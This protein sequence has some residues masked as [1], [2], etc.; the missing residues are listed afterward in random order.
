MP[1]SRSDKR[2]T[3]KLR[4]RPIFTADALSADSLEMAE[5]LFARWV[6]RGLT[7]S[8]R[9]AIGQTPATQS[10]GK[11]VAAQQRHTAGGNGLALRATVSRCFCYGAETGISARGNW[12]FEHHRGEEAKER[13]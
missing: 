9:E 10:E 5:R 4:F 6:A 2:G 11:K 1:E 7:V 13:T 12:A 3:M 8:N